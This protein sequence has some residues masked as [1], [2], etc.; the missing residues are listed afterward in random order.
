[1]SQRKKKTRT[2]SRQFQ[3]TMAVDEDDSENIESDKFTS[4]S[5]KKAKVLSRTIL[6]TWFPWLCVI[7]NIVIRINYVVRRRNWWILHPDEIFQGI[8]VSHSLVNGYGFRMYEYL[9]PIV[10]NRTT[11]AE[12]QESSLGIYSLKSFL[13]PYFYT[14]FLY[15]IRYFGLNYNS[16][17]VCKI[18][19]AVIASLLPVSVY[20]F[21]KVMFSNT[22]IAVMSS[23][24]VTFSLHIN[25]FSMHPFADSLLSPLFFLVLAEILF[26]ADKTVR[27]ETSTDQQSADESTIKSKVLKMVKLITLLMCNALFGILKQPSK[28]ESQGAGHT[29]N[30]SRVALASCV[31]GL[32]LYMNLDLVLFFMMYALLEIVRYPAYLSEYKYYWKRYRCVQGG[33]TLAFCMG[34]YLDKLTYGVWFLSPVQWIKLSFIRDMSHRSLGVLRPWFYLDHLNA[35]RSCACL[36]YATFLVIF[37]TLKRSDYKWPTVSTL[38]TATTML[39]VYSMRWNKEPRFIFNIYVLVCILWSVALKTT[40]DLLKLWKNK[41]LAAFLVS[42]VWAAFVSE[43]YRDFPDSS[44]SKWSHNNLMESASINDCLDKLGYESDVTGL[45]V[46]YSLYATGGFALINKDVPMLTKIQYDYYEYD[47]SDRPLYRSRLDQGIRAMNRM[48]DIIHTLSSKYLFHLL[49]VKNVYNYIV[50]L[51]PEKFEPLSFSEEFACQQVTVLKRIANNKHKSRKNVNKDRT[52]FAALPDVLEYEGSWLMTIGHYRKSLE[53][54]RASLSFGSKRIRPYQLLSLCYYKSGNF[55]AM[56]EIETECYSRHG[57]KKCDEPQH[58]LVL[59]QNFNM[60][61]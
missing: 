22:D 24:F 9:P 10:L 45:V 31:L 4:K 15:A 27:P 3:Q 44:S 2:P 25:V 59:N 40:L 26:F 33:L 61:A 50:T 8:E 42:F 6:P 1:M 5:T 17:I 38:V 23:V 51:T 7:V 21:A 58:R 54:L 48:S 41:V 35:N 19:H 11:A 36:N 53:R 56:K 52:V 60:V 18:V 37:L 29:F 55:T 46:D 20:K 39:V 14:P 12:D 43:S 57:Q 30:A 13:Y 47:L 34:G 49:S 16:F 32:L 28:E